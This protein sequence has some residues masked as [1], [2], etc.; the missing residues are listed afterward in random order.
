VQ[1]NLARRT[2]DEIADDAAHDSPDDR[3]CQQHPNQ[4]WVDRREQHLYRDGLGVLECED[5]E[6]CEND[7]DEGELAEPSLA[8]TLQ[9]PQVVSICPILLAC[10]S[11]RRAGL[12]VM[13]VR[14]AGDVHE[15]SLPRLGRAKR[16]FR[17][18]RSSRRAWA[19]CSSRWIIQT[20]DRGTALGK[21]DRRG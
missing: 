1:A 7:D 11:L 17:D 16:R 6:A 15:R 20:D 9:L 18:Y 5:D 12:R 8:S 3:T 2:G 21:E 4:A 14:R 19:G 13:G 10:W